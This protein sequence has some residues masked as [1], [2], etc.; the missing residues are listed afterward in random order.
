MLRLSFLIWEK[1]TIK[2]YFKLLSKEKI[3]ILAHILWGKPSICV[4]LVF[5]S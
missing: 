5:D 3:R 4:Q 1:G 2:N